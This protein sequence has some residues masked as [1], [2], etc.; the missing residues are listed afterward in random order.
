[1]STAEIKRQFAEHVKLRGYDDQYID[2][3]EEREILNF[4]V[5]QGLTVEEGLAILVRVCQESNYVL[6]REI[7]TAAFNM[8]EQF[9]INDGK[10]DKKEFTD[11]VA[12]IQ[13]NSKGTLSET[14]CK[15]KAKEMVLNNNWKIKGG[16]F[17][18][19]PDWFKKI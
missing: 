10:I 1:M 11:A 15:K 6:E 12:I 8:L 2:R 3:Q 19:L 13:R 7:D 17:G 14:Q 5:T 18:G 9:A 4:G 16:L